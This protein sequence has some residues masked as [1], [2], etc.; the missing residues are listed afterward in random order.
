[1]MDVT[2]KPEGD[3]KALVKGIQVD[4]E[5]WPNPMVETDPNCQWTSGDQ[6]NEKV[7]EEENADTQNQRAQR[8]REA[9]EVAT[10]R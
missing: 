4:Q 7:G 2:W 10:E 9:T 5:D 8:R 3:A 6:H 1:M